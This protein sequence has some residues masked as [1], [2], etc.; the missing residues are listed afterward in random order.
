MLDAVLLDMLVCP[1]THQPLRL[2]D[3]ELLDDLNASVALGEVRN[4]GGAV[5]AEALESALVREDGHLLY[6][7]RDDIPIMLIDESIPLGASS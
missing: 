6:P 2:A 1:D 5:V 7:V 4:R 3:R